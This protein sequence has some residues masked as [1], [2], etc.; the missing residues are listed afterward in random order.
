MVYG[1]L[2]PLL[3]T[4]LKPRISLNI[5]QGGSIALC[6]VRNEAVWCGRRN[7][8]SE[9][10]SLDSNPELPLISH[11]LPLGFTFLISKLRG[12]TRRVVY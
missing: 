2:W 6:F 8:G 11:Y 5:V 12:R 3:L 4:S 7:T 10:G 9:A 1:L